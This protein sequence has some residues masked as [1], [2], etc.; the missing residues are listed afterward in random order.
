MK[1]LFSG[2]KI[3][4]NKQAVGSS[5]T[6]APFC[7]I[8]RHRISEDSILHSITTFNRI[9]GEAYVSGFQDRPENASNRFFRKVSTSVLDYKAPSEP[10][11]SQL[12]GYYVLAAI[13]N[14]WITLG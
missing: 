7:L 12:V 10:E 5:E 13:K 8:K 3:T 4:M 9:C 6:L 2:C 1:I 14:S 11:T